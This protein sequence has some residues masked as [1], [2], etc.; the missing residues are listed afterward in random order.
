MYTML[1]VNYISIMEKKRGFDFKWGAYMAQLI[2][3]PTLDLGSDHDPK[4][5]EI[6]PCIW[7]CTGSVEPAWDSFS[8][9]LYI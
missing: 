3:C 1:Y 8:P 9:S 7:L 5:C 6:K 4:V 2:E